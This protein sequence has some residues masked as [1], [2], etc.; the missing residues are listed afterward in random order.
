MVISVVLSVTPLKKPSGIDPENEF[1]SKLSSFKFANVSNLGSGPPSFPPTWCIANTVSF[2]S[3]LSSSGSVPAKSFSDKSRELS[4][5]RL[6]SS[7]GSC[8]V[9]EL[10]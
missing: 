10:P 7:V 5:I 9:N 6:P 2:E 3:E 4:G 8:P 1:D